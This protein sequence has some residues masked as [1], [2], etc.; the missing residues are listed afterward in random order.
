MFRK[1]GVCICTAA[2]AGVK[3]ALKDMADSLFFWGVAKIYRYGTAVA[4]VNWESVSP[5]K[6][7]AIGRATSRLA[8]KLVRRNGKIRPGL[9]TRLFFYVMHFVQRKGFGPKDAAYWKEKGWTG[10]RRPWK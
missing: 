8:A 5:K 2:G 1:Q 4:A 6:K 3:S 10:S 7:A 9:K